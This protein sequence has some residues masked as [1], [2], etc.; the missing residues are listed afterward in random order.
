MTVTKTAQTL[1]VGGGTTG[2]TVNNFTE[3][4]GNFTAPAVLDINGNLTLTAGTFTAPGGSGTFTVA[5]NW[6]NNGGTFAHNYGA[7]TFDGAGAQAINGTAASQAFCDLIVNKGNTLS[8]GGSTL[9]LTVRDLVGTAGGFTPPATLNITGDF[10]HTL[11]TFTAGTAVNIAGNWT[12]NGGT[13]T[14]GTGT[15]T[16]NGTAA[17]DIGGA[18]ATT[19]RNLTIGN[20]AAAVTAG[21][22]F[23]VSGTLSVSASATFTP[24]AG[25]VINSATTQGTLSG[26]GTIKVTRTDAAADLVSQYKFTTRT[27]TG[28][29]VDYAGS[30]S[31]TVNNTVGTYANLKTSGSGTKTP[32]GSLTVSGVLTVGGGTT[33]HA[34]GATLTLSGGGTPLVVGGTFTPS[35]STVSYTSGSGATVTGGIIYNNLTVNSSGDTFALGGNITVNGDLTI[36]SGTILDVSANNYSIEVKGN[37]V[38]NGGTFT[39]ALRD[40]TVTFSGTGAQAIQVPPPGKRSTTSRWTRRRAP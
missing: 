20:T 16:F 26:S 1:S 17:Q 34:S 19:F 4:S 27:L 32:T 2:L 11:G 14:P 15:V 12:R 8:V 9:T 36:A 18:A 10:T 29:T 38:N 35:S 39:T 7:V 6:V 25:V 28:M 31:Q 33:L 40:G 30:G 21:V 13:F 22:N 5:G 37:W 24:D 3:T 23:D